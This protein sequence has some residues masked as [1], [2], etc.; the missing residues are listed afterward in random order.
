MEGEKA[1]CDSERGNNTCCLH[2]R[3]TRQNSSLSLLVMDC[4]KD[5][6]AQ[7]KTKRL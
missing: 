2:P 1:E 6:E 5:K 4:W 3:F 7:T